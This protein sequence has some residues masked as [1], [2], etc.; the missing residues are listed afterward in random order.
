MTIEEIWKEIKNNRDVYEVLQD[1]SDEFIMQNVSIILSALFPNDDN[2]GYKIK[3]YLDE[4]DDILN[5]TYVPV[6]EDTIR[7]EEINYIKE[8]YTFKLPKDMESYYLLD[9]NEHVKW[10]KQMIGLS[11]L[12]KKIIGSHENNESVKQGIWLYGSSNVGKTHIS[13][14]LLNLFVKRYKLNVAFVNVSELILLTQ[15][16]F[17][18]SYGDRKH[19]SYI[20]QARKADVVVIDDL[21]A[22]RPTPW[23]KE[24]VLLPIL[25]YRFKSSKT[26]I[27]TSNNSINKYSNKLINRSQDK[28][29]EED[30]N[31]KII[32]RIRSLV[33]DEFFIEKKGGE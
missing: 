28:K 13:I 32:S 1:C 6:G 8:H 23:F 17:N 11:S 14:C 33:S 19:E 16:S 3:L 27:F 26:T 7:Y 15:S 30:T 10:N 5:W 20:E 9:I 29:M 24:N 18:A 2:P 31:A 21:G 12:I 22:E 25:D 4:E